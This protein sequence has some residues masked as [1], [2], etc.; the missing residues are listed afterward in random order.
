M[1]I[2]GPDYSLF[3]DYEFEYTLEDRNRNLK[4]FRDYNQKG[5]FV[6]QSNQPNEWI[7]QS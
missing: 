4:N 2:G 1:V 6:M 3:K 7:F 5:L